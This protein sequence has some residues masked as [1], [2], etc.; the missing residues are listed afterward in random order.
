MFR[1]L[2]PQVIPETVRL[3]DV[4][5]TLADLTGVEKSPT[6]QGRSFAGWIRGTETPEYR[7]FYGETGFPFIQFTVPG[8]ERPK[9]PPMDELHVDRRRL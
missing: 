9:L 2:A 4:V 1:A 3:I 8:V 5:P 6:W 7:P